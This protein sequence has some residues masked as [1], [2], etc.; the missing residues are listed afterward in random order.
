MVE[1]ILYFL[2]ILRM[3]EDEAGSVK[4]IC[5]RGDK[6]VS[7][8]RLSGPFKFGFYLLEVRSSRE[9]SR[10]VSVAGRRTR[11]GLLATPLRAMRSSSTSTAR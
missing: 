6:E 10:M 9:E 7:R 11:D 5:F 2:A 8:D 1:G 3:I 4:M